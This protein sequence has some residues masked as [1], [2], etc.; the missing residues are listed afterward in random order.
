MNPMARHI[1]NL[2]EKLLANMR[3][4]STVLQGQ[5]NDF[6]TSLRILQRE[7]SNVVRD[8][9]VSMGFLKT[10]YAVGCKKYRFHRLTNRSTG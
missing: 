5:N 7:S 8:N 1:W 10:V 3:G 9:Y 6:D 2:R 4:Q